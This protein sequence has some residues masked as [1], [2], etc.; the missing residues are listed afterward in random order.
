[1]PTNKPEYMRAY[2]L[3]NKQKINSRLLKKI[4][5]KYCNKSISSCNFKKHERSA[6]HKMNL[7]IVQLK[8]DI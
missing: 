7:Q 5:C 4:P 2:Y 6:K 8:G 1:M 3:K